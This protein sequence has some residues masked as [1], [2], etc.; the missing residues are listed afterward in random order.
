M[1]DMEDRP[2]N[3]IEQK[4]LQTLLDQRDIERVLSTYARAV[5]RQDLQLLKSCYHPDAINHNAV[6]RSNAWEFAELLLPMMR[7]LF[8]GT[9]HH[10]THTDIR[11]DG[12]HASAESY[13]IAW[14]LVVGGY[15]EIVAMFGAPYADEMRRLGKLEGGHDFVGA[16]RYLDRFERRDSVWRI[17]E[18]N[19]TMEWNHYG[20]VTHGTP[21]S[22]FGRMPALAR[23]DRTDPVYRLF[24]LT[25]PL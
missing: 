10:V 20:A 19:V 6:S 22:L 2:I 1:A 15:E 13:F 5:D 21:E 12:D 24:A 4:A 11:V 18:R 16:G 3:D 17:A 8:S 14:H 9:M 7:R 25:S 23:R